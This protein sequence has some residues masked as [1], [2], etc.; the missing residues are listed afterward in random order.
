MVQ[1]AI[2]GGDGRFCGDEGDSYGMT[3]DDSIVVEARSESNADGGGAVASAHVADAPPANPAT[4]KES[5][6]PAETAAGAK[7]APSKPSVTTAKPVAKAP[8]AKPAPTPK[9]PAP[10]PE[11]F[12]PKPSM[13]VSMLNSPAGPTSSGDAAARF[14]GE[15]EEDFA[16]AL[17]RVKMAPRRRSMAAR[18]GAALV[19]L[20]AGK[21]GRSAS[22]YEDT[23]RA[24]AFDGFRTDLHDEKLERDRRY[25]TV[26]TVSEEVNAYLARLEMPRRMPNSSLRRTWNLPDEMPEY[27]YSLSLRDG[28]LAIRAGVPGEAC[29]RLSY[30]SSS[31]PADFL[32]RIEFAKP[33]GG[34]QHRLRDKVLEIIVFKRDENFRSA[35]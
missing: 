34:F 5:S 25:G 32:T 28:V 14:P 2:N 1:R 24:V 11:P 30:V 19:R 7:A 12:V 4:A 33:V 8:A 20:I 9:A 6:P 16:T 26:Y 15:L 18:V 31:F 23:R 17:A 3:S 10:P 13:P 22:A 35:A 21:S 27:D 29:R